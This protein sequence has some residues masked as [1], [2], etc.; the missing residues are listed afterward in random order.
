MKRFLIILLPLLVF[1]NGC[2][3]APSTTQQSPTSSNAAT[4]TAPQES[5]HPRGGVA[6]TDTKYFKGSIGNTLDLQMKLVRDGDKLSGQYFYQKIGTRI[7][8][9]GSIDSD[10]K[11]LLEEFDPAGKQTGIFKGLW[12]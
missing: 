2:R 3:K 11:V 7:D 4:P 8:L 12:S 10:N 6:P 1:A 5:A 9:K